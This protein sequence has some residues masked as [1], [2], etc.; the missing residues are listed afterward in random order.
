MSFEQLIEIED[1]GRL[2][3]VLHLPP[4][5][6]RP[7]PLVIYC[8]GKNGERYEVHRLAVK[9]ARSLAEKG[10]AFL[11]FDYYGMGLSDGFYH[12]MTTSTKVSNVIKA[13][14]FATSI[15][16]I[17]K[18]S[19][20]YLGFSDGA[21]IALMSAIQTKVEKILLWSPLFYEFGGNYPNNMHPRFTRHP[22]ENN[23][24]V[25]PWAGLWVSMDF[26]RDLQSIDIEAVLRAYTGKSL[27]I[28]GDDDPLIKEEF[29]YIKT[30]QQSLYK[31]DPEHQVTVIKDAGHLFTS[32]NFETQLM[33]RS[34]CWLKECLVTSRG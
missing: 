25:M 10:I 20:S 3:G 12:Q 21:R 5:S 26:Y 15:P 23:I 29:E 1:Q 11:R 9:F 7:C 27:V 19:I 8:P 22:K 34:Y 13:Y 16:G 30:N 32:V 4:R 17:D 33:N 2:A 31:N 14:E 24:L 6:M 28:Y 18:D